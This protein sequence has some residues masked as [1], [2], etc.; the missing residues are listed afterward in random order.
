MSVVVRVGCRRWMTVVEDP[1]CRERGGV[2]RGAG[3]DG[4]LGAPGAPV[5]SCWGSVDVRRIQ[6][7]AALGCLCRSR[8]SRRPGG[9]GSLT[10]GA[11]CSLALDGWWRPR[12]PAGAPRAQIPLVHRREV[13]GPRGV[14]GSPGMPGRPGRLGWG[15]DLLEGLGLS[16]SCGVG[17]LFLSAGRATCSRRVGVGQGDRPPKGHPHRDESLWGGLAYDGALP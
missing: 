12:R 1:G 5:P 4:A 15:N 9:R 16:G 17:G 8:C 3:R 7:G 14:S 11:V 13:A 10:R 2:G 6:V